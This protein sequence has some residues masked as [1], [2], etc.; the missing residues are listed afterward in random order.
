MSNQTKPFPGVAQPGRDGTATPFS[1]NRVKSQSDTGKEKTR[2]I[3]IILVSAGHQPFALL[4]SQAYNLLRPLDESAGNPILRWPEPEQNRPWAEIA[5]QGKSLPVLEL[6]RILELP[7]VE[8][9]D[10]C[11][12]LLS[13]KN[14]D[15]QLNLFGLAVDEIQTILS[16]ISLD[17]I[18]LLPAWLTGKRLGKMIWGSVLIKRQVFTEL[19]QSGQDLLPAP[20]APGNDFDDVT[21]LE[22]NGSDTDNE[23]LEHDDRVPVLLLDLEVIH[24]RI[25]K[26]LPG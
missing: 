16:D 7:L 19:A 15:K 1:Y 14:N 18:R 24:E 9:L 13:G 4:M 25:A 12:I 10:R 8:P 2:T 3:E 11:R 22:K 20:L 23:D 26:S 6:A 5:F 21:A 17:D